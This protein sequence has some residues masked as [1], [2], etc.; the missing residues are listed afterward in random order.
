MAKP[1]MYLISDDNEVIE[2]AKKFWEGTA[3]SLAVY[4]PNQWREGLESSFFRSQIGG[5]LP[6]LVSGGQSLGGASVQVNGGQTGNGSLPNNVVP[7]PSRAPSL[8]SV[9]KISSMEASA[10]ENAISQ[11]KGNL[12]EAARALGIGRATLYRKVKQYNI[13]PSAA[14]RRRQAA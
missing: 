4:S 8:D 10:I 1:T 9:Q 7:F 6:S 5:G 11:F 2:K 13:D 3:V 12:T 14:R